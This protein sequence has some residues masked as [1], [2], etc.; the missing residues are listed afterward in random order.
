M[1]TLPLTHITVKFIFDDKTYEVDYFDIKFAQPTD[2][3]GQP[4][5][6]ITGG[7][8]TI[9]LSQAADRSLY[10]WG[11]TSTLLKSG[12]ILFQSDLGMTVLRLE[13]ENAY[14][15]SLVREMDAYTATN[16]ILNIYPEKVKLNGFE[17]DN[18]W[19]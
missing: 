19:W 6:E 7:H 8:I 17:H 13:F 5:H 4:Q 9:H 14:C 15:T 11:K 2:F 1:I 12:S 10:I 3:R 18:K 16:T